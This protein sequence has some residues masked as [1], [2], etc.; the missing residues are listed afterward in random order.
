M[1]V[2]FNRN[3]SGNENSLY[4]MIKNLDGRQYFV[5]QVQLP[6]ATFPLSIAEYFM[7]E[8]KPGLLVVHLMDL[9]GSCCHAVGITIEKNMIYDCQGKNVLPLSLKNPTHCYQPNLTFSHLYHY[10]EIYPNDP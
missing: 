8:K 1:V 7:H 3:K 6:Y 4:G 10:C 5:R 9:V 2:F